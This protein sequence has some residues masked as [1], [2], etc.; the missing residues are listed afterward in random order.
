MIT[1]EIARCRAR[2]E[3]IKKCLS[4]LEEMRPGSLSEQ[5]NVCGNPTCRCKDSKNPQKHGPYYQ[6]SYT[7]KGK[8]T[9]EFVKQGMVTETR[10]QLMNYQIFKKMTA[11]WV[12]LSVTIAKLRKKEASQ[13]QG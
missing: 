12:E 8:S 3:E 13:K 9:T 5:Y 10:N 2:I 6:L 11:E 1:N 7:H 4:T